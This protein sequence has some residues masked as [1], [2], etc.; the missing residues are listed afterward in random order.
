MLAVV[1]GHFI[2]G[3]T[4]SLGQNNGLCRS[5]GRQIIC[6]RFPAGTDDVLIFSSSLKAENESYNCAQ[7]F[8][9]SGGENNKI[10]S[11]VKYFREM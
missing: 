3:S 2:Q 6:I 10:F 4:A 9:V 5:D 8:T 11:E 1:S 7:K